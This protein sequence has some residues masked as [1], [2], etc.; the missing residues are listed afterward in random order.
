MSALQ[1]MVMTLN[2]ADNMESPLVR[3]C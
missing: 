3:I 1:P 2:F